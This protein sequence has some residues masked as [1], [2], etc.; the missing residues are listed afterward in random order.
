LGVKFAQYKPEQ[1]AAQIAAEKA[2]NDA[3][4]AKLASWQ[5][6]VRSTGRR[7]GVA[8]VAAVGA[9]SRAVDRYYKKEEEKIKELDDKAEA[10]MAV[11]ILKN[12]GED[13]FKTLLHEMPHLRGV[14]RNSL[15]I[16][17]VRAR[18]K[19]QER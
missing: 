5:S 11:E 3:E 17:E 4:Q 15:E 6:E 16:A 19:I 8:R 14:L 9:G 13:G 12:D 18:R 2:S 10:N 1:G 7:K